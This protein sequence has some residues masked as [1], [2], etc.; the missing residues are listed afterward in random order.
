[1]WLWT[2]RILGVLGVKDS[3]ALEYCTALLCAEL[4]D[5]VDIANAPSSFSRAT[6]AACKKCAS[7]PD[8]PTTLAIEEK[9]ALTLFNDSLPKIFFPVLP[10]EAKTSKS[11][12]IQLFLRGDLHAPNLS[13]CVSEPVM[14]TNQQFVRVFT[15]LVIRIPDDFIDTSMRRPAVKKP[16]YFPMRWSLTNPLLFHS[17]TSTN[18]FKEETF[19]FWLPTSRVT[20]GDMVAFIH[21][22]SRKEPQTIDQLPGNLIMPSSLMNEFRSYQMNHL[23]SAIIKAFTAPGSSLKWDSAPSKKAKLPRALKDKKPFITLEME[24]DDVAKNILGDTEAE[25]MYNFLRDFINV[26]V[27]CKRD[28]YAGLTADAKRKVSDIK[29]NVPMFEEFLGVL[30]K[31]LKA[32]ASASEGNKREQL[33]DYSAQV[34]TDALDRLHHART[35]QPAVDLCVDLARDR[36]GGGISGYRGGLRDVSGIGKSMIL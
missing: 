8:A 6:L 36:M 22:E 4:G 29:D 13:E 1:M 30:R 14:G 19:S 26:R 23:R 2:L 20:A 24:M 7:V 33:D 25:K 10:A 5:A 21:V 16:R 34:M 28:I 18:I 15:D 17:P 32:V 31:R 3:T 12:K 35:N 11:A 27:Y 9:N